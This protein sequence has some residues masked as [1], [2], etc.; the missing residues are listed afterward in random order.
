MV[1]ESII[2]TIILVLKTWWWLILPFVLYF[3]CKPLYLWWIRWEIWY[4]EPGQ[5]WMLLE[6]IP[7]AEVLKPFKAMEDVL[8]VLWSVIDTPCWREKWCE[9][10]LPIGGG[11]WFSFEIASIGGKIHYYL[12]LPGKFRKTA[13]SALYAHF[14]D[15]EI[16]EVPDYTQNVLQDI[17]NKNYGLYGEDF[18]L[19]KQKKDFYPIK[20]YSAFFEERPE[21]IKEEK[22]IDPLDSLLEHMVRIESG[23]QVWLQIVANPITNEL[24]PWVTKGEEK[25]NEIARRPKKPK[26][27]SIIQEVI[28]VFLGTTPA[29]LA[30]EKGL[31]P[32]A[33]E[34]TEKEMLITPGERKI[35]SAIGD[36]ASKYAFQ[37]WIRTIYIHRR[38]EPFSWGNY[39]IGRSYFNHF[40]TVDLNGIMFWRKTRTRIHY[41]FVKRRLY[42]RKKGMFEKAVKRFP[43]K[44]PNMKGNGTFILN[45][46]ELATIFHFPTKSADLPPGVPRVP[47]KKGPPPGIPAI[48]T[49]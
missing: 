6:I 38:D 32:G 4:K 20:T 2:L 35:L 46:E 33:S 7:P 12:R 31:R 21:A 28:D 42:S 24:I 25:A 39:R 40:N 27:K 1:P 26:Q 3:L 15:A 18:V 44:Y 30:K 36:K 29:E 19:V 43:P 41:W 49:E 48:P 8:C 5:E 47:V 11:Q 16:F 23:E 22:R 13:E 34:E 9:G 17:P 10:E 37:M 14:P 45:T